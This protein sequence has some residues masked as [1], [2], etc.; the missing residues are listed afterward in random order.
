MKSKLL[1]TITKRLTIRVQLPDSSSGSQVQLEFLF[2]VVGYL[3]KEVGGCGGR[4]GR[5]PLV[6]K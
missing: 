4:R 2:P 1:T 5:E 6:S 3:P